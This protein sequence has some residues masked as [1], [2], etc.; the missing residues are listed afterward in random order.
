MTS[1]EERIFAWLNRLRLGRIREVL[2]NLLDDAARRQLSFIDFLEEM[3]SAE[4]ESKQEKR[5]KMGQ[6]V[7]RFPSKVTIEGFDFG[8]QPSIDKKQI[9]ELAG[10]RY[11]SSGENVLLIGS[12]GVG[13]THLAI[14]LGLKAIET[15]YS[16]LFLTAS[17][18]LAQLEK[19][20][21]ENR[22]DEELKR[23]CGP[24]LLIIDELGYLPLGKNGA[25]LLFQ[26]VSRRYEKGAMM[27]TSNKDFEDWGEVFG[28]AM[29]AAALLDRLLHHSSILTIKG[30]SYRLKDKKKAGWLKMA[31][32]SKA[33][34]PTGKR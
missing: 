28:D 26:L 16:T 11:V 3:L 5:I 1:Q 31:A 34:E 29:L 33:P 4:I 20:E 32:P 19:A 21:R 17:G 10:C 30:E 6:S 7:A 8:F 18:L 2:P 24:K 14:A 13:K 25:N 23:L 12:P 27:I 22:L 15:G 9:N